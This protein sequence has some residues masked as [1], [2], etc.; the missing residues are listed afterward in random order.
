VVFN[1][2]E[3]RLLLLYM[4]GRCLQGIHGGETIPGNATACSDLG[5]HIVRASQMDVESQF[6]NMHGRVSNS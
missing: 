4:T 5:T 3:E 6:Q 2:V 1:K